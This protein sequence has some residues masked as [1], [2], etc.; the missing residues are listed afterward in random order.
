M[1]FI[2]FSFFF[3]YLYLYLYLYIY[4]QACNVILTRS[5]TINEYKNFCYSFSEYRPY[6]EIS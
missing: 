2:L 4:T 3:I 6:S 5:M 1:L